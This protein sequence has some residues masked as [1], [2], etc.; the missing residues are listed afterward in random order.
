MC[1][2]CQHFDFNIC[3]QWE[4]NLSFSSADISTTGTCDEPLRMSVWE[5]MR[6]QHASQFFTHGGD[7]LLILNPEK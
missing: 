1:L 7:R 5:A 6:L 3:E 4:R 2:A